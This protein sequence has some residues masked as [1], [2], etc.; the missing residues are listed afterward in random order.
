MKKTKKIKRSILYIL[1]V[2]FCFII[3]ISFLFINQIINSKEKILWGKSTSNFDVK[4]KVFTNDNK[5]YEE[6]YLD[7][8]GSYVSSITDTIDFSIKYYFQTTN[9]LDLD[10]TYDVTGE[11]VAEVYESGKSSPVWSKE[12]DIE[13]ESKEKTGHG[14]YLQLDK[15]IS[16]PF[17]EYNDMMMEYKNNYKLNISSYVN[18]IITVNINSL[19][20]INSN[21][22]SIDKLTVRI[23]LLQPTF[24]IDTTKAVSNNRDIYLLKKE[25]NNDL[26]LKL[27]IIGLILTPIIGFV[28]FV[29]YRNKRTKMQL[30]KQ[31]INIILKKYE[32][33]IIKI[34][35]LPNIDDLELIEITDFNDLVDLEETVKVPIMYLN[36]IPNNESWF[37]LMHNNFLYR[38]IVKI[39]K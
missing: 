39:D 10:Y 6:Q 25:K 3:S 38:Y 30:Y 14:N 31:K 1:I 36:I 24:K 22:S 20:S 2:M 34:E 32:E 15:N 37:I 4:Y 26:F 11:V 21:I 16:I 8:Y 19:E 18:F 13:T 17:K 29:V 35:E 5:F 7:E 28:L 12:L 23:P 9:N 27:G 33:I